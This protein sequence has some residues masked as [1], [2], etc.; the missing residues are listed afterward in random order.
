MSRS[1]AERISDILDAAAKL[2]EIVSK[3]RVTFDSNWETRLAAERLIEIV[4]EAAGAVSPAITQAHP[5]VPF[6]DA[7]AMRNFLS[8]EY[9][10]SASDTLWDTIEHDDPALASQMEQVLDSLAS[11]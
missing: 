5:E 4:G 7:K 2:Q 8:H 1:D 9:W 3:G 6:A 10:K 11:Q